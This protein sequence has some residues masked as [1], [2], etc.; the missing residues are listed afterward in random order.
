MARMHVRL[1]ESKWY[2]V[3]SALCTRPVLSL[4]MT[5]VVKLIL[6][7]GYKLLFVLILKCRLYIRYFTCVCLLRRFAS[8]FV[9]VFVSCGFSFSI[10][11]IIPSSICHSTVF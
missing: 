4:H 7:A 9:F 11:Q 3:L 8:I 10:L 6:S 5:H 2:H 1:Y